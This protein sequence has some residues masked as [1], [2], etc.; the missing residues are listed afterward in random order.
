MSMV[1][2]GRWIAKVGLR[3]FVG[4][5]MVS[6]IMICWRPAFSLMEYIELGGRSPLNCVS[7]PFAD[8]KKKEKR[9]HPF[10]WCLLER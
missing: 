3:R 6:P 8:Q 1:R 10:V 5:D 7:V 9:S 4:L 2:F